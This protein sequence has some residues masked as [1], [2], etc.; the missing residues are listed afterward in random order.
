MRARAVEKT[1]FVMPT[2]WNIAKFRRLCSP[3]IFIHARR[4]CIFHPSVKQWCGLPAL[5]PNVKKR[6]TPL[7][8]WRVENEAEL[9]LKYI[10]VQKKTSKQRSLIFPIPQCPHSRLRRHS[11]SMRNIMSMSCIARDEKFATQ[12]QS[13]VCV[14]LNAACMRRLCVCYP[15]ITRIEIQRTNII[16]FLFTHVLHF[17]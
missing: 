15:S 12:Y 4:P 3:R 6:G 2:E 7:H 14:L 8:P 13:S 11:F 9:I 5:L 1:A 10:S 16:T 17:W